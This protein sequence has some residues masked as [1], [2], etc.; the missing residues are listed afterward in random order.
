MDSELDIFYFA[1]LHYN[2]FV[3]CAQLLSHIRFF[4]TPWIVGSPPGTFVYGDSPGKNAIVCCHA[5]LQ[6]I[7]LTWRLNPGQPNCRR[8]WQP[9]PV[10]L[11]RK[12]YGRR[13][14]VSMGSQRV[15]HDWATSLHLTP[16]RKLTILSWYDLLHYFWFCLRLLGVPWT[17]RRSN[18]S[19]LKEISPGCS[20]EGMML[21]L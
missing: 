3:L 9:T 7:F 4:V 15:G 11:P 21:K 18:Q 16:G 8:K 19:I 20:L 17:A 1:H 14:L 13:S 2:T 12:F 10:L 5:L 6:G